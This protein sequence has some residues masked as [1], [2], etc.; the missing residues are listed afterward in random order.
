LAQFSDK[1]ESDAAR[2]FQTIR[3]AAVRGQRLTLVMDCLPAR[4]R[5]ATSRGNAAE[6]AGRHEYCGD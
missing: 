4:L 1:P 3:M 5:P 6:T 2:A